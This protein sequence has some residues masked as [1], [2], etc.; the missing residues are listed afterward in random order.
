MSAGRP[1]K[2]TAFLKMQMLDYIANYVDHGDEIPSIAGFAVFSGVSRSQLQAWR[3]EDKDDEYSDIFD[4]LLAQQERV[5]LSGGLSK[6]F[7]AAVTNMVLSKHGYAAKQD[8]TSSDGSMTP[9][10][11]EIKRRIIKDD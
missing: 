7:N 3:A 9:Q 10:V 11:T 6:R 2:L 8:H 1:T 5:L 4:K